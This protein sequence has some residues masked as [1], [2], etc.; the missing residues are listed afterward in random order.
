MH[1]IQFNFV[2]AAVEV[3]AANGEA[4]RAQCCARSQGEFGIQTK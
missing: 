4:M 1:A 2:N 3:E